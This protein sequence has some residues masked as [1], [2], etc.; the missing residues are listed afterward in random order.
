MDFGYVLRRAWQII[1]KFK[2]LWIFGILASCGQATG[3]GGSN[4]GYRYSIEDTNLSP[5]IEQFF[6]QL[7]P[8]IVA[9]LIA[10][11]IIVALALIVISILL[12]TVGR[13]G[14]IRGTMKAEQGAERLTFGELWREGLAYFWRVFGLNLL[15]GLIIFLAILAILIVGVVLTVGT[16]G[17]FILCL[18]PIICLVIPVMWAVSI[19]IE[20]ANVALVV[21]NL[22]ITDA[23]KRGWQVVWG[24]LG[25]MIVM[26]LILVLGV[27][28][29]GGAIIG[30]P[31]LLVAAPAVAGY[32]TG[33]A[34]AIWNGWIVSGV[35]FLI[36]LPFLLVL[37][38]I[39]KAYISSAWTLTFLR[40]TNKP[41]PPLI[42][43]PD[44]PEDIGT[45]PVQSI[46]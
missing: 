37:S 30:L 23:I 9:L 43:A 19:V 15:I 12:G 32:A 29:I 45:P 36:Y 44:A 28:L 11:G 6:N 22:G 10:L 7:D 13:V 18:L 5:R 34:Q 27:S 3:S 46:E 42:E 21:E 31:L 41:S 17:L 16:L 39:L 25:T 33:G 38:G 26:G 14:L 20:Q 35:L 24:N 4:S 2:I 1:W 40:L 8:T